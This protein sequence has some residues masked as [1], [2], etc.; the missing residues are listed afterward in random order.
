VEEVL[1]IKSI[2]KLFIAA[3]KSDLGAAASHIVWQ[4]P[5]VIFNSQVDFKSPVSHIFIKPV[6]FSLVTDSGH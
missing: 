6:I 1:P 5:S 3:N 2:A 4:P